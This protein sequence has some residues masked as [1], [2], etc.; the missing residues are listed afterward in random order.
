MFTLRVE[1]N[2]KVG[3]SF[4]VPSILTGFSK[5][6]PKVGEAFSINKKGKTVIQEICFGEVMELKSYGDIMV[7]RTPQGVYQVELLRETGSRIDVEEGLPN[8]VVSLTT[9]KNSLKNPKGN[10]KRR[11]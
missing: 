4:Y 9:Y 10:F 1:W 2:S 11:R 3:S 5:H 7:V 8:N 6:L